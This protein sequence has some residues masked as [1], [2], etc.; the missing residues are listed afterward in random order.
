MR[1]PDIL[2]R[3]VQTLTQ[4]GLSSKIVSLLI[5]KIKAVAT[6]DPEKLSKDNIVSYY[7]YQL[8][9]DTAEGDGLRKHFG[10]CRNQKW[11]EHPA[12]GK[13]K[14]VSGTLYCSDECAWEFD[15]GW[16]L[17]QSCENKYPYGDSEIGGVLVCS[18]KCFW[19]FVVVHHLNFDQDMTEFFEQYPNLDASK[20]RELNG[21]MDP[22]DFCADPEE[23]LEKLYQKELSRG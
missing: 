4:E 10:M 23:Y 21:K 12:F 16:A 3:F 11:G 6:D 2:F 15:D 1:D 8:I 9:K 19:D 18:E 17:C 7:A 20:L 14:G 13:Y 22:E 5:S